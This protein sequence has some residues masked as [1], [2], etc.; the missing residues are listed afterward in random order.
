MNSKSRLALIAVM[1]IMIL[2]GAGFATWAFTT[3]VNEEVSGISGAVTAAI[4]ANNV[5]VTTVD[6]SATISTLYII[7][8]AP[9][10]Q[11]GLV[12]GNGI[13]WSTTNDSTAYANRITQ[14]KLIGSITEDDNDILDFTNYIGNFSCSFS[15]VAGTWVNVAALSVDHDE[16]SATKTANVEYVVNLPAV[17][18]ADIPENVSEVNALETEVNALNL[19]LTFS[20]KVKSV[21][22]E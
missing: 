4:E 2:I 20:F 12:A 19:T 10:G 7:C 6:G 8:D 5:E 14:V 13:Y 11:E 15:A 9:S 21:I 1:A 17:S 16:T 18:Y 3:S 22:T